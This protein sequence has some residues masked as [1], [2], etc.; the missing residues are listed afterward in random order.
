M[1]KFVKSILALGITSAVSVSAVQAAKYEVFDRGDVDFLKFS[2]AQQ[3]NNT[4]QMALSGTDLFNLPVQFQ[5]LDEDDFD[6]IVRLAD[7]QH[8]N[9]HALNDIED[10][11]AL[12]AGNPTANDFS[13]V[14]RFLQ[15]QAG[16]FEYQKFGGAVAMRNVPSSPGVPGQTEEFT[17]FDIPFP[18]T[19]ILTRSTVDYVS[20]ITNEGW[21]YGTASAPYV[22]LAPFE[23]SNGD[24]ETFW[25]RDFTTRAYFSRD[26]GET[27]TPLIPPT[28]GDDVP[29][30]LR[31][32][33][34]S[35]IFDIS[36]DSLYAVGYA[37]VSID[38]D[39]IDFITD[40]SGG[41]ADVDGVLDD[42]PFEVCI[43]RIVSGI[44]NTEAVIWTLGTDG[45]VESN[46]LGQLVTPNVDDER[47]LV[48]VAQAVNNNG[49]AVGYATGW[50]DENET[51]PSE[52]ESSSLY[53]VVYK[54]GEVKDFTEDHGKYFNSRA[55]DINDN[56][57]AVGHVNV[58]VNGNLRTKFYHVDTNDFDTGMT[59]IM[60]DDF[61]TGSSST[62]RAINENGIIVGEGEVETHND[63]SSNPRRRHAFMYDISTEVFT[64]I[65]D[66]LSCN[67]DYDIIEARDINDNGVISASALVK[68]P[69]RDSL[70]VLMKDP[71]TGEQLVEDVI[72]AVTIVPTPDGELEDCSKV[73]EK[74]EREGAGLGFISLVSLLFFGLR[75]R[76]KASVVKTKL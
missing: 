29:E 75:R 49:V 45:V 41:C 44:Y 20:G 3:E 73:E 72:R 11:D 56:G 30:A 57:I 16:N 63:S 76:F 17:V 62:A 21:I 32:G 34:E 10:E 42:M 35:A 40:T 31:F 25:V 71:D 70:G 52:R 15:S 23:Q 66:L 43:G 19:D 39:A 8:E 22:A 60:P 14:V 26:A 36:G 24:I 1:N 53:A 27:I 55:Y 65:N 28:E 61:F 68:V 74:V 47:E 4:N 48:N 58:Y 38:Q 13:W 54:E 7:Y 18:G 12:R 64:D 69:R 67:S 46:T 2:Y 6:D 9:V 51:S 37:S 50:V 59:M 5:Y 33:G